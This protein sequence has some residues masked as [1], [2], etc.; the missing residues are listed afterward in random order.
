MSASVTVILTLS[1]ESFYFLRALESI[2]FQGMRDFE[3]LILA[4]A[5]AHDTEKEAIRKTA[6]KRVHII[7]FPSE[8]SKGNKLNWALAEVDSPYIVMAGHSDVASPNR[9]GTLLRF[10]E[11][12]PEI[13]ICGS[14]LYE[15][16]EGVNKRYP[17]QA[18]EIACRTFFQCSVY[19]S[20]I[21]YRSSLFN[22]KG[23]RFRDSFA[24]LEEYDLIYRVS[25]KY[26]LHNLDD[27]LLYSYKKRISGRQEIKEQ[28][29]EVKS[30]FVEKLNQFGVHP[31]E[32][33]LKL[34][35]D[36]F[37]LDSAP[38]LSNPLRYRYWFDK[39]RDANNKSNRY[40]REAF[41]KELNHQWRQL[42]K[43]MLSHSSR[44]ASQYLKA[45]GYS[46]AG[47]WWEL[48]KSKV[49]TKK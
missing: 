24:G 36:L 7:E 6:D 28:R 32:Q 48:L 49:R 16:E 8:I 3:L 11:S 44:K 19:E 45:E 2:L 29:V 43:Y 34:Q 27:V 20:A 33:E 25:Q 15:A 35:A 9:L 12:E 46:D 21:I 26:K 39:L 23:Y 13:F 1:G 42:Y 4:Q 47:V 30:F 40:P 17:L 5:G 18:D 31:T 14:S 41:E 38:K 37:A 10:M 22:E